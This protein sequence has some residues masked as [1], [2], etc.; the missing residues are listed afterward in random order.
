[1]FTAG[2]AGLSVIAASIRNGLQP[3]TEIW[4]SA[5]LVVVVILHAR[6]GFAL[7]K[8]QAEIE[9]LRRLTSRY[10]NRDE[11][12]DAPK[13]AKPSKSAASSAQADATS[14]APVFSIDSADD[15]SEEDTKMLERVRDAIE[16][17]R[18]DLYLQ[19]IV[20]LPQRK[21]RYYEAFSRLRDAQGRI[22]RLTDYL[23]AAE[24]SN[25]IGDIDNLILL[26]SVQ[27]FRKLRVREHQLAVFCNISPAT[28][29]DT[30][31]F[32]QFTDYLE[33]NA[34]LSTRLVFE[35]TYPAIHMMHPRFEENLK[36]IAK[37][38]YA[39]S[40]DHVPSLDLDWEAL[41]E[42]NFRFVKAPSSLLLAAGGGDEVAATRLRTFRKRI[43]DAGIDLIAEKIEFESHMPEV[44]SL[45]ID[46][47]QGNLFGP[48][49]PAEFYVVKDNQEADSL[50][51]AS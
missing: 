34:D 2:V 32:N 11:D 9:M 22:L 29:F 49:R 27:A 13:S 33:L 51:Q 5:A 44:L 10:R 21:V 18:V 20:S 37:R 19:P 23:E 41:R 24:R 14:L 31:F 17:G 42:K 48:P 6:M 15:L 12:G 38:G 26:R 1:M 35:F 3:A 43:S 30:E 39:F 47:G 50:A 16:G 4:L 28:L 7:T 25:R 45:G 46:Y 8:A 36:S 40:I